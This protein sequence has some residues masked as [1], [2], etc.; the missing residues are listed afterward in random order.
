MTQK[1]SMIFENCPFFVKRKRW[2]LVVVNAFFSN[3]R[4][5]LCKRANKEKTKQRVKKA[6]EAQKQSPATPEE[7]L[8][9]RD[10]TKKRHSPKFALPFRVC[11]EHS[12]STERENVGITG[13][14]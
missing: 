10:T 14:V 13:V 3:I 8:L 12:P 4:R 2:R 6:K 7:F 9:F 5:P 1:M 11:F